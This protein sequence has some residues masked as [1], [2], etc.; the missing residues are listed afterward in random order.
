MLFDKILYINLNRR[1]DRRKNIEDQLK[2]IKLSNI[3]KRIEA[4]DGKNINLNK[5][6]NNIITQEGIQNAKKGDKIYINLTVGAIGC[7]LSHLL[8]YQHIINNK[9]EKCLIL[10]DDVLIDADI[11]SKIKLMEDNK[12]IPPDFDILFL[13]CDSYQYYFNYLLYI[14]S[15]A[16]YIIKKNTYDNE[17][18]KV[19]RFS[20]LYGYILT[21]NGAKKIMN[22][23]GLFPITKQIDYEMGKLFKNNKL[24]AYKLIG[25]KQLI[26]SEMSEIQLKFKTDIQNKK[27]IESMTDLNLK[28]NE[29][30]DIITPLNLLLLILLCIYFVKKY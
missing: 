21:L 3:A 23:N 29:D 9:I 5:I 25:H 16:L 12:K 2:K 13:G 27:I 8:C 19:G 18:K 14:S 17:F 30:Y 22:K 1:P 10:E 15:P 26:F 11:L 28:I 6:P 4:V 20:G 7:A 24:K